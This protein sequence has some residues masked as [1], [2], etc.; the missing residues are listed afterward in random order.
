MVSDSIFP[1]STEGY[2]YAQNGLPNPM[3]GPNRPEYVALSRLM[4]RM[5]ISFIN[6]GDPNRQLGGEICKSAS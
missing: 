4:V 6:Y 1:Y 3:G 2:G 5:W